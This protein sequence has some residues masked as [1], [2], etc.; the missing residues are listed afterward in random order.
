MYASLQKISRLPG[1]TAVYCAHEYTLENIPFAKLV[2]PGNQA[3]MER[4]MRDEQSVDAGHPT[5]PST[6]A[7]ENLTNPF[8]RCGISEVVKSASRYAGKPLSSPVDVFAALR[9]WRDEI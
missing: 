9:K 7:L 5:I 2:E 3:L 8:L 1:E 6:I 4:E